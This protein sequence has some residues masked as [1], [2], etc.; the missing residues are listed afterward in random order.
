MSLLCECVFGWVLCVCRIFFIYISSSFSVISFSDPAS[1]HSSFQVQQ[2][3]SKLCPVCGSNL[4][5]YILIKGNECEPAKEPH[6]LFS[7]PIEQLIHGI[8]FWKTFIWLQCKRVVHLYLQW[9]WKRNEDKIIINNNIRN[10]VQFAFM[11]NAPGWKGITE[12]CFFFIWWACVCVCLKLHHPLHHR[13]RYRPYVVC[14]CIYSAS[15]L[16]WTYSM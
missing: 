1:S 10:V 9:Q 11:A 4:F 12:F 6:R 15:A 7:I 8:T 3:T 5:H 13:H 14:L 2:W 16:L